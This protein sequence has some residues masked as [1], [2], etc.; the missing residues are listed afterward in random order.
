[1]EPAIT[2]AVITAGATMFK[3]FIESWTKTRSKDNKQAKVNN[4]IKNNYDP[5]FDAITVNSVRL[6]KAAESGKKFRIDQFREV[7]HPNIRLRHEEQ[8]L[9]DR[10]FHYRIEYLVLIGVLKKGLRDYK[11]SRLRFSFLREAR[12]R[13]DYQGIL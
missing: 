10:E 7:L 5:L 2:T 11:I 13:G 1:M 9:F 12:D 6:L 8:Y 3:T 4:W